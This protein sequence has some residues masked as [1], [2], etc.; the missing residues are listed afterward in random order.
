MM[1]LEPAAPSFNS[2]L[3]RAAQCR[4]TE[5]S[6]PDWGLSRLIL[7]LGTGAIFASFALTA[8]ASPLSKA[9]FDQI[10]SSC[11]AGV[12]VPTLRAVAA[13]ESHFDPLAIR[14]NTTHESWTPSSRGAAAAL[15]K[16]RLKLGNSVDIGLMQINSANLAS[17]GME[18]EDGFDACHSLDAA[19]R[20]LQTAFSAGSSEAERQAA[21]LITLSRYNTGRP[22]AGIA[23]G[24]ADQVISAQ[25]TH[26]TNTLALQNSPSAPPQWAIWGGS[27][28][29]PT[30][31]VVTA[32]G[33]SEI[34]KR[35]GALSTE[36]R[37]EGRAAGPP[38]KTGEPYE[39]F[40][41]RESEASRP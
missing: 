35:A 22:L 32:D 29:E 18:V 26:V 1:Q 5:K 11:A 14:D 21:I 17:L 33:S 16:D 37:A 39:L 15:A 9:S 19:R 10:A 40:A 27:G 28:V 25:H 23:N 20:I 4:L 7:G 36:A 30:S 24:Y 2:F 31:W 38:S 3:A 12:A 13:V 6:T 8:S 34:E 41:Y